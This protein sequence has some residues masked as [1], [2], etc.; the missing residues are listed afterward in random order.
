M[1]QNNSVED[2]VALAKTQFQ[3]WSMAFA[4]YNKPESTMINIHYGDAITF[5]HELAARNP[6]AVGPHVVT[7]LYPA[8]WSAKP[9]LLNRYGARLLRQCFDVTDTSKIADW[10][11]LWNT[12]L[13]C[14]QILAP[15]KSSVLYTETLRLTAKEPYEDLTESLFMGVDLASIFLGL[16]PGDYLLGYTTE[17]SSGES[18][19][20]I[21]HDRRYRIRIPWRFAHGSTYDVKS[22]GDNIVFD[23]EELSEIF[24]QTY[25]KMFA[26][27][28]LTTRNPNL[29]WHLRT[30][31]RHTRLSFATLIQVR[32]FF[33]HFPTFE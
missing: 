26:N 27:E 21:E 5:C 8:Q 6:A 33:F 11:G 16:A 28:N 15:K 13:P 22:S 24:F 30:F 2:M 25:L 4:E 1:N 17:N 23:A 12:L 31:N 20:H 14:A 32:R 29:P 3:E 18:I 10:V 9:L 7:R 19:L